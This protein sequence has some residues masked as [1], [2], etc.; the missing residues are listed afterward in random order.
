MRGRQ[1]GN[2]AGW[3]VRLRRLRPDFGALREPGI[4]RLVGAQAASMAGDGMVLA[5]M[6]FAVYDLDGGDRQLGYVMG[7]F[8][9]AYLLTLPVGGV[10][11]DRFSR[12]QLMIV[13]DLMRFGSQAVVAVLWWTGDAAIWHLIVAQVPLGIGSAVF[14]PSASAVV[15]ELA[16]ADELQEANALR[17]LVQS[18]GNLGGPALGGVLLTAFGPGW[19]FGFDA[20]SFVVSAAFL[21][22]LPLIPAPTEAKPERQGNL[23]GQLGGGVKAWWI[24]VKEGWTAFRSKTWL[25]VVVGKFTLDNGLIIAPFFIFAPSVANDSLGGP[26]AW[27]VMLVGLGAGEIVGSWVA[28]LWKPKRPLLVGLLLF[29]MWVVPLVLLAVVAPVA[30]IAF[31]LFLGGVG[32]VMFMAVWNT[33]IQTHVDRQHLA[34]VNAI[35]EFGGWGLVSFGRAAA[36]WVVTA[37]GATAGLYGGAALLA[38]TTTGALAIPSVRNLPAEATSGEAASSEPRPEADL[39]PKPVVV[40]VPAGGEAA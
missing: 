26:A 10:L 25:W 6:A 15:P 31:G 17:A 33:A 4:R 39:P 28:G 11:G 29:S 35:D 7:A 12:K 13:A 19:V 24:D 37:W 18:L 38:A 5:A 22:G 16:G 32:Q 8:G 36:G 14:R 20:A 9:I 23:I 1:T 30:W 40:G 34:R 3:R 21:V 2:G 27:T